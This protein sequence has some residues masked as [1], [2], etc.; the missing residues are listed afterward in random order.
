MMHVHVCQSCSWPL[1][2]EGNFGTEQDGALSTSYC[3]FCYEG[4]QFTQA[5]MNLA[6]MI[7]LCV[8]FLVEEGMTETE[9]RSKMSAVLPELA[10][11]RD[12]AAPSGTQAS[13]RG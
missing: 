9:A 6:D 11:W 5:D 10:R 1:S 7:D 4:G 3:R 2:E 13:P 12:E 8:P